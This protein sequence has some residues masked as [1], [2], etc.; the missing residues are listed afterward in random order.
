MAVKPEELQ[1]QAA[2]IAEQ[3]KATAPEAVGFAVLFYNRDRRETPVAF[4]CNART[5][6]EKVEA[7]RILREFAETLNPSRIVTLA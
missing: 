6:A 7:V 3:I 5:E 2:N 1:W 4:A